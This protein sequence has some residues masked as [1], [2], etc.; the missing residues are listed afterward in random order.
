M[1]RPVLILGAEPRIAV[2]IA[3]SLHRHQI[4]VDVGVF[5]P[6]E[7]VLTSRAV[8]KFLRFPPP[9]RDKNE[10]LRVTRG[11]IATA[12]YDT[13]IPSS[14]TTLAACLSCYPDLSALLHVACPPPEISRRVLDKLVTLRV[15]R[16]CGI[17]V[18]ETYCLSDLPDLEAQRDALR[19]PLIA[20]PKAKL[21]VGAFKTRRLE[22]Y[23][24][25]RRAFQEDPEFGAQ[26]L[27]QE[28]CTGVG[29]GI[30]VLLHNGEVIALF[31]HRRLKEL[32]AT[33]GVSVL[34]VAE[35]L[36]R[37][38]VEQSVRLLR[39]LEWE[40]VAM[41]E[42]L[43]DRATGTANLMEVNGRY[44]GSLA[45]AVHAGVDFP[46]WQWQVIHGQTP[47]VS[48]P[49]R[50]GLRA[51]W[52]TGDLLR[53]HEILF[54]SG[55][56]RGFQRWSDLIRFVTDFRPFGKDMLWQWSDP[57]PALSELTREMRHMVARPVKNLLSRLLPRTMKERL[58][59]FR[60]LEPAAASIYLKRQLRQALGFGRNPSNQLPADVDSVVFV[61]HG[62][63]IR[64]PMAAALLTKRI[65]PETPIHIFSAG[66]YAKT[67]VPADERASAAAAQFGVSLGEHRSQPFTSELADRAGLILV[68]DFENE[69]VLLSRFPQARKKT[70]LLGALPCGDRHASIEIADPYDGDLTA[71]RD[72]YHRLEGHVQKLAALLCVGR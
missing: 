53:L 59:T 56:G 62:N 2:T 55:G 67:G 44:W 54:E 69:A 48:R 63:I 33:G 38:L 61:C 13:L 45:L 9:S 64:S 28:L 40:G 22:N 42:F 65:G 10:F 20:K 11:Q 43:L 4:P 31:Q 7:P 36:D 66:L 46:F 21:K 72:C 71:V 39:A 51:R 6:D 60:R 70:Y 3:R 34:A 5:T 24:E 35:E 47:D 26:N 68:M 15:A 49:Y 18:P 52:L 12:G 50:R 32:P 27:I 57:R 58:R 25:L 23:E 8:R 17:K 41:V 1:N 16:Q 19:F 37:G 29:V 30:E 14:D